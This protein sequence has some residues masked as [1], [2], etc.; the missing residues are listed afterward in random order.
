MRH[1]IGAAAWS[2]RDEREPW[3]LMAALTNQVTCGAQPAEQNLEYAKL[4]DPLV[5]HLHPRR[6]GLLLVR[7]YSF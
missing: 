3:D 4:P 2:N 1:E 5:P 7:R 6:L